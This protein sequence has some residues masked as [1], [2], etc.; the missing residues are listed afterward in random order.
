VCALIGDSDTDVFAG[1]LAG[2]PVIGHGN[3]RGEAKA[4]THVQA[5]AISTDLAEITAALRA[6]PLVL[7]PN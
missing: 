3:K 7:L 1:L 2:V 4:L 6:T 5:A